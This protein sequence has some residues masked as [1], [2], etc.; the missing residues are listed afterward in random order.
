MLGFHTTTVVVVV[1]DMARQMAV[2]GLTAAAETVA[3]RVRGGWGMR[4]HS[5]PFASTKQ[6]ASTVRERKKAVKVENEQVSL[7]DPVALHFGKRSARASK[8]A[9]CAGK[10]ATTS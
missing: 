5:D 4:W 6:T 7:T 2:V 1:A 8:A 3:H 9:I 10:S